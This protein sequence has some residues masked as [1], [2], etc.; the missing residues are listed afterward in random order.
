RVRRSKVGLCHVKPVRQ[1]H[2]VGTGVAS[3]EILLVEVVVQPEEGGR[4]ALDGR[5][6]FGLG[7]APESGVQRLVL[8]DPAT[9]YEP[10]T[11]GRGIVASADQV[12]ALLIHHNQVDG[13]QRGMADNGKEITHGERRRCTHTASWGIEV[14]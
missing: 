6:K 4:R 12:T 7:D 13:Y 8:A 1:H 11:L 3:G 5:A 2:V 14:A 10:V 9:G